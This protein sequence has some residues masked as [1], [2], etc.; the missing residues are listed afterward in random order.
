MSGCRCKLPRAPIVELAVAVACRPRETA[1]KH[2]GACSRGLAIE[3]S[4]HP[5][6]SGMG[7]R[8]GGRPDYCW[9]FSQVGPHDTESGPRMSTD[10]PQYG[11][12]AEGCVKSA[13]RRI[14]SFNIASTYPRPQCRACVASAGTSC[15]S[16]AATLKEGRL[17]CDGIVKRLQKRL[18]KIK[19]WDREAGIYVGGFLGFLR[20]EGM[21]PQIQRSHV[22]VDFPVKHSAFARGSY[23]KA[24]VGCLSC[25][26]LH[27][28]V[29][30]GS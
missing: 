9:C 27:R 1:A 6:R 22:G 12:R 4:T 24:G 17:W 29:G 19:E 20:E 2:A 7:L 14:S 10:G 23:K 28:F 25:R 5:L 26:L 18:I 16:T 15:S 21:F 8:H 3:A 13:N 30:N 11:N